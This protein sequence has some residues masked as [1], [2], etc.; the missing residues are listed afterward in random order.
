MPALRVN[1]GVSDQKADKS[2]SISRPQ[3]KG[4]CE[5]SA[6]IVL[7]KFLINGRSRWDIIKKKLRKTQFALKPK[8]LFL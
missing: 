7:T 8:S 3:K 2:T 4:F 1:S 6:E 5:I